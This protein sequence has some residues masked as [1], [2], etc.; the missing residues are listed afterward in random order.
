M[1]M[2]RH[3]DDSPLEGNALKEGDRPYPALNFNAERAFAIVI[4]RRVS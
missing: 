1:G 3:G 2:I 4:Y